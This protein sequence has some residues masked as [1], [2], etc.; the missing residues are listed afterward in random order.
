MTTKPMEVRPNWPS[1]IIFF[2]IMLLLLIMLMSCGV[3]RCIRKLE[4][5]GALDTVTVTKIDTLRID[6]P[7]V[8]YKNLLKRDTLVEYKQGETVIRYKYFTKTDSIKIEADCP[9][10]EVITKTEKETVYVQKE[11]TW[12]DRLKWL[13]I[14]AGL[15]SLVLL[16][17]FIR[18]K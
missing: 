1:E 7:V 12:K 2:V 3:N 8:E 13:G 16:V 14:G 11:T 10:K 9:D 4:R 18:R 15:F 5:A 6:V 17:I